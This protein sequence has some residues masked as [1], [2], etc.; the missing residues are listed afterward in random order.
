MRRLSLISWLFL[1]CVLAVSAGA[2]SA[3][4]PYN[5]RSDWSTVEGLAPGVPISIQLG[6]RWHHCAFNRA[7]EDS[8]Q[9]SIDP[10]PPPPA[11]LLARPMV[12]HR[13]AVR[14]IR[15]ENVA[16]SIGLGALIGAGAGAGL[17]AMNDSGASRGGNT[18]VG[19]VV[20]GLVG[21]LIGRFAPLVHGRVIYER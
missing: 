6:H 11:G 16:G 7:D 3:Q 14:K 13:A 18:T 17:G 19:A 5:S 8:I 20:G 1:G 4:Q 12:Y 10:A 15:L 9:C 21:G 2:Q